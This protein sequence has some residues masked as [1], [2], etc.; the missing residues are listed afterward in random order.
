MADTADNLTRTGEGTSCDMAED[1]QINS[2]GDIDAESEPV[3]DVKHIR[4][5]NVL[6]KSMA[7][8][9]ENELSGHPNVIEPVTKVIETETTP[10]SYDVTN[11]DTDVRDDGNTKCREHSGDIAIPETPLDSCDLE[12]SLPPDGNPESVVGVIDKSVRNKLS[13]NSKTLISNWK[14]HKKQGMDIA[15]GQSLLITKNQVGTAARKDSLT[16][17]ASG[18][19]DTKLSADKQIESDATFVRESSKLSLLSSISQRSGQTKPEY[20]TVQMSADEKPF[21]P[22]QDDSWIRLATPYLPLWVAVLCLV[23]NILISGSGII[24]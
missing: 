23:L 4:R 3:I 15:G 17:P 6:D 11:I 2:V 13:S 10:T 1:L 5:N 21:Q 14:H 16:V 18:L 20:T 12:P 19:D 7:G 24:Q 9:S 22:I 8:G